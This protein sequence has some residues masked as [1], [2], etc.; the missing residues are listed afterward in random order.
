[1]QQKVAACDAERS[2]ESESGAES[3]QSPA[4][5][6]PAVHRRNHSLK[7]PRLSHQHQTLNIVIHKHHHDS[8]MKKRTRNQRSEKNRKKKKKNVNVVASIVL[9]ELNDLE[10][11]ALEAEKVIGVIRVFDEQKFLIKW[12]DARFST[13]VSSKMV[14]EKWPLLLIDYYESNLC[15][16]L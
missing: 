12:K 8:A 7:R 2:S 15:W 14:R 11:G 10:L 16:D 9:R 6:C 1:M 4:G 3:F 13:L 5:R